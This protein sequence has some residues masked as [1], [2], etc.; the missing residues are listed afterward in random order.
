MIKGI[1]AKSRWFSIR[2]KVP[3]HVLF[4]ETFT[5]PK[6]R[7]FFLGFFAIAG[8]MYSLLIRAKLF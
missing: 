7:R 8:P 2:N 6:Y 1:A 3:S 5:L 4:S